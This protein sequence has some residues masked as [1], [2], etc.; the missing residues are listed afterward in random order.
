METG[1][2]QGAPATRG[3]YVLPPEPPEA[4]IPP[5]VLTPPWGFLSRQTPASQRGRGQGR[6]PTLL[7]ALSF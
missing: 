3:A 5:T 2:A 4:P 7:N 6:G 1:R